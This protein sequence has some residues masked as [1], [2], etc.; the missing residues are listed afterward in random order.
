M[1][2]NIRDDSLDLRLWVELRGFEPL[3]PSMRTELF[4][5]QIGELLRTLGFAT[6]TA[7]LIQPAN[8][9]PKA[10]LIDRLTVYTEVAARQRPQIASR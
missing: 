1:I 9:F 3:T 8:D 4:W 7:D 2:T 10:H 5:V 6:V